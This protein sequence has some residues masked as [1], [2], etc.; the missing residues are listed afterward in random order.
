M[1]M[2]LCWSE[3]KRHGLSVWGNRIQLAVN[4]QIPGAFGGVGGK[5]VYI[6]R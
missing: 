5:A 2:V 6:G 1:K 4:V 3:I